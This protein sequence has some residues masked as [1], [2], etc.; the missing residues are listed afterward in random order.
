MCCCWWLIG[1]QSHCK[2]DNIISG[3]AWFPLTPLLL[4]T[5][6]HGRGRW[7]TLDLRQGA[8]RCKRCFLIRNVSSRR[9]PIWTEHVAPSNKGRRW[10]LFFCQQPGRVVSAVRASQHQSSGLSL[11]RAPARQILPSVLSSWSKRATNYDIWNVNAAQ[12][13]GFLG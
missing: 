3:Q 13:I 6:W 8:S 10:T 2:V 11:K 1:L 7:I 5:W 9:S 12:A 4:T